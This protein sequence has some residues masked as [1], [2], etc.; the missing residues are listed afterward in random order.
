[1]A[2]TAVVCATAV[3]LGVAASRRPAPAPGAAGD[4]V[5]ATVP[6]AAPVSVA[7][8]PAADAVAGVDP[9]VAAAAV[10]A[11]R[12]RSGDDVYVDTAA[13]AAVEP[14]EGFDVVVV[15]AL[16]LRHV[17]GGWSRP[18]PA[19]YA[20]PVA[21]PSGTDEPVA[22]AKPWPLRPAGDGEPSLR[23]RTI[24][25]AALADTVRQA[26][27]VAGFSDVSDVELGQADEVP[28]ALQA[29]VRAVG[30]DDERARDHTVWLTPDGTAVL[31]V[32]ASVQLPIPGR[33]P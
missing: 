25:D 16:V 13:V 26:L 33:K 2:A 4:P 31:G 17:D 28:G 10:L 12:E 1:M 15:H 11:V 20:V 14:R 27:S 19:R 6:S 18:E 7:T 9:A 24:N 21:S 29:G 8:A 30:P 5:P 23:W 3:L 22:L 32:P